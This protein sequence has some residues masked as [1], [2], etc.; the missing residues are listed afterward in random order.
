MT[1]AFDLLTSEFVHES[2]VIQTT[3]LSLWAYFTELFFLELGTGIGQTMEGVKTYFMK[4]VFK[5][6]KKTE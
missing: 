6:L 4:N 3:C 1:L 2:H 5:T